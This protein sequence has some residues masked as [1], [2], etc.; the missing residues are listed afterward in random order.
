MSNAALLASADT[1]LRA[2]CAVVPDR[3]PGSAGNRAATDYVAD[4][5]S[6]AGWSVELQEFSCLDWYTEG[7]FM[8][9][10]DAD[11]E[12]TPSPY[13]LGVTTSGPVRVL[14]HIGDLERNDLT[15]AVV[16]LTGALAVEPLTP[17]GYPFYGSEDHERIVACLPT[18]FSFVCAPRRPQVAELFI[19]CLLL[20]SGHAVP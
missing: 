1:H 3:R 11:V 8:R 12:V 18:S 15:G 2:L 9:I 4:A 6:E 7:G 10:G 5:M 13:G 16:V 17:K 19:S 20:G 14:S